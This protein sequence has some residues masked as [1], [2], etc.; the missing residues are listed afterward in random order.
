MCFNLK[1]SGNEVYYT[2]FVILLVKIMLCS[3]LHCQ[4]VLNWNTFHIKPR[5]PKPG[6]RG[7][8][9]GCECLF[10]YAEREFFIDNLLVRIHFIIVMIRRTGLAPWEFEFPFPGSLATS[11]LVGTP[12]YPE[13]TKPQRV[14]VSGCRENLYWTY[15]IGP[16]TW[17]TREGS[18]W[19]A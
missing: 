15:D 5:N 4:R 18:K 13:K 10:G 11:F 14:Q 19:R 1:L 7:G 2:I 9:G 3:K 6:H 12:L 8:A 17:A 16:W